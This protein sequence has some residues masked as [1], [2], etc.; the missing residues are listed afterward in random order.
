[1]RCS[2]KGMGVPLAATEFSFICLRKASR[3]AE[4]AWA[5]W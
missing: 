4:P 2:A 1:M 3:F 5:H